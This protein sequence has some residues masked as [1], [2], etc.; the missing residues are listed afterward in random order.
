MVQNGID[1]DYCSDVTDKMPVMAWLTYEVAAFYL[2]ILSLVVFLTIASVK[3]F[4]T[5][6]EREGFAGNMRKNLDFLTYCTEDVHWFQ[7][8]FTQ[9]GLFTIGILFRAAGDLKDS[10][11]IATSECAALLLF[12]AFLMAHVYYSEDKFVFTTTTY[13]LLA[14]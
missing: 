13:V 14:S 7:V 6:R 4:R 3:K 5:F 10:I 1:Y 12:G 8:W 9:V 2:N 11:G